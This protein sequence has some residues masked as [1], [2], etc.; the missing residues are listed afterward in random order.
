MP[1]IAACKDFLASTYRGLGRENARA[2][3]AME[4]SGAGCFLDAYA[5]ATG[6]RLEIRDSSERPDFI[7]VGPDGLE[8]GLELVKFVG[9]HESRGTDEVSYR[10]AGHALFFIPSTINCKE[11]KRQ[12]PDWRFPDDTILVVQVMDCSIRLFQSQLEVDDYLDHGFREIWLADYS[13]LEVYGNIEVF[14]LYPADLFGYYQS[15]RG[16]PYG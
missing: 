9:D 6:R 5:L 8:T 14:C 7:C 13:E 4:E 1:K 3:K 10:D 15:V 12:E 2:K 11:S 16:K